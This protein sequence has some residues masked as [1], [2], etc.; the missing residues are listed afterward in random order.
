ML[1]PTGGT[2]DHYL[3]FRNHPDDERL[4]RWQQSWY[5]TYQAGELTLDGLQHVAP[6]IAAA[7]RKEAAAAG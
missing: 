6:L 2:I 3:S 5:E 1:D 4:I 7:V